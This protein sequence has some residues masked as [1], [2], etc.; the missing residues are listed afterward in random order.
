[1][2]CPW[3]VQYNKTVCFCCTTEEAIYTACEGLRDA[4]PGGTYNIDICSPE[5]RKQRRTETPRREDYMINN[6]V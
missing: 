5:N 1:M 6:K 3:N 2:Y 4:F